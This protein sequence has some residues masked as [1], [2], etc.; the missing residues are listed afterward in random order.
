MQTSYKVFLVNIQTLEA[1]S[2]Y[3]EG[4]TLEEA[5]AAALRLAREYDPQAQLAAN[6]R[7]VWYRGGV[8]R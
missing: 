8:N 6:G 2:G 4:Q 5:Q 7:H 3:G 1:H